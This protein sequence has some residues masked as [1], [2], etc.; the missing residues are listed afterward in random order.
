MPVKN[1]RLK[2]KALWWILTHISHLGFCDPE[3]KKGEETLRRTLG[4]FHSRALE[5]C[6][7]GGG[8][9]RN[10]H[11]HD[12]NGRGNWEPHNLG[13]GGEILENSCSPATSFTGSPAPFSSPAWYL[14]L[15]LEQLLLEGHYLLLSFNWWTTV[16]GKTFKQYK[17][18]WALCRCLHFQQGIH[19]P[20]W[21]KGPSK[22]RL[23]FCRT[24]S[25]SSSWVLTFTSIVKIAHI[26]SQCPVGIPEAHNLSWPRKDFDFVTVTI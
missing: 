21:G 19:K 3:A 15:L 18:T 6:W 1:L 7:I 23:A 10:F 16:R 5:L 25:A 14:P 20:P 8:H 17:D 13:E 24:V 12:W 2:L 9:L 26:P 22:G 4:S 11:P